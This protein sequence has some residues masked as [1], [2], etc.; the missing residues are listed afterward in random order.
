[1]SYYRAD[2]AKPVKTGRAARVRIGTFDS[3]AR[4]QAVLA[5]TV[6][7]FNRG[8]VTTADY[9]ASVLGA[10]A[11]FVR[12]YASPYGRAVAKVY[13]EQFGA[14]PGRN[15]LA[16]RGRRLVRVAAYSEAERSILDQGARE[17]A[18]TAALLAA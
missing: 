18:R 14:E 13:R 4:R 10:S 16:V 15:G 11:D 17:Y 1:M 9:L 12:S 7:R 2:Q 3:V 6:E 8:K 5:A